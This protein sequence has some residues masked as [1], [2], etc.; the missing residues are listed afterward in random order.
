MISIIIPCYNMPAAAMALHVK[1]WC[2][3][4]P[5]ALELV[6]I[7]DCSDPPLMPPALPIPLKMARITTPIKWNQPGA[8]NL[9]ASLA[10]GEWLLFTDQDHFLMAGEARDL[11]VLEK[12]PRLAYTFDRCRLHDD[13]RMT[14]VPRHRGTILIHRDRFNEIGGWDEDFSGHYG[15]DDTWFIH[16]IDEAI[17]RRSRIRHY[18]QGGGT[19]RTSSRCPRHNGG[20]Y[21]KKVSQLK[22][23][24]YKPGETLRF[25]WEEVF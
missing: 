6:L 12:D 3:Y 24:K 20:V 25:D 4:S 10:R 23:G 22:Q 13:G 8:R 14:P 5:T 19:D 11:I 18:V 2:E 15:H 1:Q 7:D 9:G 17:I 16:R 21:R